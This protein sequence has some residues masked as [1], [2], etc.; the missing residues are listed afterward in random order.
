[1]I[2]LGR[3]AYDLGRTNVV[4][5]KLD[6][7]DHPPIKQRPYKTPFSERPNVEKHIN[8]MLAAGVISPSNSPWASPIVVVPKIWH[9]T[10]LRGLQERGK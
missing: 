9:Q 4:T 8:D 3:V 7:G 2:F 10:C 6:T 1:M 5:L